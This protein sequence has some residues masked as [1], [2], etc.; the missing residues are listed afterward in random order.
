M[1]RPVM[2]PLLLSMHLSTFG[3]IPPG[4][5]PDEQLH[6]KQFAHLALSPDAG[7][8]AAA[9]RLLRS[10]ASTLATSVGESPSAN[11]G[12][13]DVASS[14]ARPSSLANQRS[15]SCSA[16]TRT[17]SALWPMKGCKSRGVSAPSPSSVRRA[18][19]PGMRGR[20]RID[21]LVARGHFEPGRRRIRIA[22]EITP[23]QRRNVMTRL[24]RGLGET[25]SGFGESKAERAGAARDRFD[26]ATVRADAKVGPGQI[27]RL[28]E[29]R[30]GDPSTARA[31][32][33]I[34]P[35]IRR[36]FGNLNAAALCSGVNGLGAS[37]G[38]GI[39][40]EAI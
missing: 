34:D 30:P 38:N 10:H 27:N 20:E 35:A 24:A 36:S 23:R 26:G 33:K 32:P 39:C 29:V 7:F 22:R 28:C 18:V 3:R 4:V 31:A 11:E 21:P 8:G 6:R 14:R 16:W 17:D 13:N 15:A 40:A 5:R 19:M 25:I 37:V 1:F 12:I 2:I 9:P